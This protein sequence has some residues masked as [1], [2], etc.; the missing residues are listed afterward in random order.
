MRRTCPSP[1]TGRGMGPARYEIS[2]SDDEGDCGRGRSEAKPNGVP[3]MAAPCERNTK[4]EGDCQSFDFLV[5]L[6]FVSP[7]FRQPFFVSPFSSVPFS[8]KPVSFAIT[9]YFVIPSCFVIPGLTGYLLF[10]TGFF[11]HLLITGECRKRRKLRCTLG[12]RH[13]RMSL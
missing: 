5:T 10:L 13:P 7:F 6:F 12:K 2:R 3:P 11:N 4:K 9:F 1:G 8:V